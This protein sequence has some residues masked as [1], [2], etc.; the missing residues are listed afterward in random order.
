VPFPIRENFPFDL[1][2]KVYVSIYRQHVVLKRHKSNVAFLEAKMLLLC[3]FLLSCCL[4]G[5]MGG[6]IE[7]FQENFETLVV[8][9]SKEVGHYLFFCIFCSSFDGS[10]KSSLG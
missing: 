10:I 7:E 9:V 2:F 8:L 5:S 3:T 1:I 6:A 4:S